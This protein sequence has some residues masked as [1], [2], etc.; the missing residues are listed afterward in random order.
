MQIN[1]SADWKP[2]HNHQPV[3]APL[4][5]ILSLVLLFQ[6][7]WH[8]TFKHT[9]TSMKYHHVPPQY[10]SHPM[11]TLILA[12]CSHL[13]SASLILWPTCVSQSDLITNLCQPVWS[14]DQ[15]V[16]ASLTLWPACFSQSDLVTS[17]IQPVWPC[18]QLVSA[19]LILSP[20]CFSQSD[21]VTSLFQPVWSCDQLVSASLT[22][23]PTCVSQSDLVTKLF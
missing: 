4:V 17:L 3:L 23:S 8:L 21:L 7:L 12:T 19:S 16:S 20:T 9:R 13:V 22:L 1:L 5:L 6:C 11:V 2:H 14:C 18:D 15:L 10:V